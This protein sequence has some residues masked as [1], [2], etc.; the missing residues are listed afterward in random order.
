ME[1]YLP[2][3]PIGQDVL[4]KAEE[5][6]KKGYREIEVKDFRGVDSK[7][8]I[9]FPNIGQ[10]TEI[11]S[12][13][14]QVYNNLFK[15]NDGLLTRKQMEKM[16][17]QK[18]IWTDEDEAYIKTLRDSLVDIEV[19]IMSELRKKDYRESYIKS[20]QEKY[21]EKRDELIRTITTREHFFSQTIESKAEEEAN[22]LKL[23]LCVKFAD[24]TPVWNSL[25]HLKTSGSDKAI[26][27]IITEAQY[28]WNGLS[29]EVLQRLP[30][31]DLYRGADLEQLQ[32]SQSGSED[33]QSQVQQDNPSLLNPSVN[34]EMIGLS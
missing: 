13:Y 10:Q 12:Y 5:E 7:I 11:S 3:E 30:G 2:G 32:E 28:L 4:D 31:S 19:S 33:S 22:M 1:R 16:L 26:L 8:R 34:G 25:E 29:K 18:G 14:S 21:I 24:G 15:K 20:G 6:I 23:A 9:Y 17:K 27:E